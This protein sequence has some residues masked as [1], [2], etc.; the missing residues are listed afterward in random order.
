MDP[1][2]NLKTRPTAVRP[3]NGARAITQMAQAYRRLSQ[4]TGED[5][6]HPTAHDKQKY[7]RKTNKVRK[8]I[9]KQPNN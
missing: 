4:A 9:N 2:N 8:S 1:N 6:T 3:A 7:G 5:P